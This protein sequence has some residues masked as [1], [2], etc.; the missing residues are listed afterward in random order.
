MRSLIV[1]LDLRFLLPTGKA[2]SNFTSIQKD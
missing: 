2:M 1:F